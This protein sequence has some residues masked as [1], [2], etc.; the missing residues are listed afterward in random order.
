MFFSSMRLTEL[1]Q[2]EGRGEKINW[3]AQEIID[4][5]R[6]ENLHKE[7]PIPK[8]LAIKRT[9]EPA[10]IKQSNRDNSCSHANEKSLK[11]LSNDETVLLI[12][13]VLGITLL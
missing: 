2:R 7:H 1:R 3:N 8:N 9:G 4:D 11:V 5:L 10:T 12:G 6:L 13:A